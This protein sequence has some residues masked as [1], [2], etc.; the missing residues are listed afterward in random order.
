MLK[1][2]QRTLV[3]DTAYH[4]VGKVDTAAAQVGWR[5][6]ELVSVLDVLLFYPKV[7][8][9]DPQPPPTPPLTTLLRHCSG[10]D[11]RNRQT[12]FRRIG[13]TMQPIGV[14][15]TQMATFREGIDLGPPTPPMFL[16][17]S[18]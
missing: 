15:E 7:A 2:S 4:L 10:H 6:N 8:F 17:P 9:T 14:L 1:V 5:V 3:D 12:W 16:F 13:S 18:P 11:Q